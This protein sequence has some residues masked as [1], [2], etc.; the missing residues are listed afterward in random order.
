MPSCLLKK[1]CYI[2]S[3]ALLLVAAQ[4]GLIYSAPQSLEHILV[5]ENLSHES[6]TEANKPATRLIKNDE[7][8]FPRS[9]AKA[10][11]IRKLF[12]IL[13]KQESKTSYF[14][15]NFKIS[16]NAGHDA[17]NLPLLI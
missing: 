6:E 16:P 10:T 13:G 3:I 11:F 14:F 7:V 4:C 12:Q 8:R 17:R 9:P 1:I 15:A 2:S 5:S